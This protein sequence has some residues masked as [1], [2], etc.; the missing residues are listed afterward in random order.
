MNKKLVKNLI[1]GYIGTGFDNIQVEILDGNFI[2]LNSKN[3]AT[4]D[5]EFLYIFGEGYSVK[6]EHIKIKEIA[7]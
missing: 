2:T 1:E 3:V 4:F 5:D 6:I 7:I